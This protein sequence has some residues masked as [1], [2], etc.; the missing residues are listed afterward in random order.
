MADKV[1]DIAG[2]IVNEG[3]EA[4]FKLQR[5]LPPGGKLSFDNAYRTVGAKAG[6]GGE[7]FLAW[8]KATV[9]AGPEWVFYN[10]D[11][12]VFTP[13][14]NKD[15]TAATAF[16]TGPV[17]EELKPP[18]APPVQTEPKLPTVVE[19][20]D[21]SPGKGAGKKLQ[22]TNSNQV[23]KGTEITP[24]TIILAEY[25][26]ATGLIDAC[27]SKTVLKKALAL[28]KHF[29]NKEQHMRYILK[30]MEQVS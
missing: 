20:M 15:T 8:L 16:I 24:S 11:G 18:T 10:E 6:V 17:P 28:T 25:Q 26:T 4:Y 13:A 5:R 30:R 27:K 9:F 3:R 29:S 1:F 14:E 23:K 19:A 7:E 2:Y 22:R 21:E 12:S